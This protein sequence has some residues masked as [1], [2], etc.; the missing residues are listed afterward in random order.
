M[1]V[2]TGSL[3]DELLQLL[4]AAPAE[5][6]SVLAR[7]GRSAARA[8][9]LSRELRELGARAKGR[10]LEPSREELRLAVG[11][12]L[13]TRGALDDA[14]TV[15][16]PGR[17]LY[18]TSDP[19]LLRRQ[20]DGLDLAHDPGRPLLSRISTDEITPAWSCYYYNETLARFCLVGLRGGLVERD[21][22]ARGGFGV[23]VA[24]A[25]MGSGSSRETAPY[26]I[27]KAGI[28]L[29]IA[30]SFEK[31]F[32]QNCHNIGLLTA[33]DPGLLP[34]IAR[35]E[36]LPLSL[37]E[38]GLDAISSAI[39]RQGGLLPYSRAR[40]RGEVTPPVPRTPRRA[41]TLAEKILA[42]HAVTDARSGAIGV[43]AVK[44][45]DA[46]FV[47]ADVR[48]SH[49]YVTPM[50]DALFR[51]GF[52]EDA[53]VE[54]PESVYLFRDHLTLLHQVMP[55]AQRAA[56]LLTQAS[57]LK[58]VQE[59]FAERHRLRLF[60]EVTRDDG[61]QSGSHAICHNQVMDELAVPGALVIGTD[62][63]T[64]MAGATGCLAFGVGSTDMAGA[65]LTRDV[66]VAVPE[67]V[68]VV[69][70]GRLGPLVSA[71]DVMLKLLGLP[72]FRSRSAIGKVLEFSGPGL[73]SL[74][75][76]E[77]ATLTNMACEA[78][79]FTGIVAADRPVIEELARLRGVSPES[80]EPRALRPD[81]DAEYAA[82][83]EL[84]LSEVCPMVALPSDP[85]NGLP[86][87]ELGKVREGPVKI[88]IAYGGSCT[89][90]KVADM[91][92]YAGVLARAEQRG[93]R[94][95]PGV[96][97][98][99]QFG[100]QRIR[101]YA[102]QQGYLA[103]FERI[104]ATLVEPSCGACIRAGPGISTSAEQVTVSAVNRN[105]PGRSGPGQVYLAS[106]F[107]V[108]ASAIAGEIV[109]PSALGAEGSS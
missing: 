65:W 17:V 75:L 20:L 48:F 9:E 105:Y 19:E 46:L 36:A 102:E 5:I 83:V 57:S 78:S 99:I 50:A 95:A 74:S 79:A 107:T 88:D 31:I 53:R 25:N 29:I 104:G 67:S 92:M 97:L 73:S 94:V 85:G 69:L 91:D 76:D 13:A 21:E 30:E 7:H 4:D 11:T 45:G 51:A 71:K 1:P 64:T 28:R 82:T 38:R 100:S 34:R 101:R 56:G 23:L 59:R 15:A 14:R 63:H 66:R 52:G 41:M 3:I 72:F 27:L 87:A 44:P 24:G 60:G 37:F 33:T 22:I 103:L 81:P 26:A 18:L 39:V 32:L 106:P 80:L 42:A 86:V 90:G 62:S 2:V 49:E 77:R 10:R 12:L 96:S 61:V 58:A 35:R 55:E 68:R 8:D 54:D 6:E 70:V 109:P 16:I 93:L 84:D 98:F 47:R 89:G 43:A 40:L 108:A